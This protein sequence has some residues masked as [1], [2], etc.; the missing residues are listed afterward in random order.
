MCNTYY[1][2]FFVLSALTLWHT[3]RTVQIHRFPA[4]TQYYILDLS[5]HF[6]SVCTITNEDSSCL[7]FFTPFDCLW[8]A[9]SPSPPGGVRAQA[10][11]VAAERRAS[12][13]SSVDTALSPRGPERDPLSFVPACPGTLLDGNIN[14]SGE[15]SALCVC[16]WRKCKLLINCHATFRRKIV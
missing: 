1:V 4:I 9:R 10:R 14:E 13:A 16:A 2:Y 11:R 15:S 5:F 6:T 8:V 7:A 12:R 3:V